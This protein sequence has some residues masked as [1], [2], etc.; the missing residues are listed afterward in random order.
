[1]FHRLLVSDLM[2]QFALISF[3][4]F[5]VVFMAAAIWALCIPRERVRRMENLPLESDLTDNERNA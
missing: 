3:S 1:M 5:F 2:N 4:I